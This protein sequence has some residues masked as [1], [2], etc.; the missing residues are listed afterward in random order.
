M[1]LFVGGGVAR[2][3]G[4]VRRGARVLDGLLWEVTR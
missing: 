4:D 2:R 1:Q 3:G